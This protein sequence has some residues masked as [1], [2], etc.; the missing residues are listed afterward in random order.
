M[1]RVEQALLIS[2]GRVA[3]SG[4]TLHQLRQL[5]VRIA[6]DDFGAGYSSLSYVQNFAYDKLKIDRSFIKDV[7]TKKDA[8]KILWA[9]VA[10]VRCFGLR[11]T[12]EGIET[13]EQLDLV[14]SEGCDEIQGYFIG[15][16]KPA[17]DVERLYLSPSFAKHLSHL[18]RPALRRQSA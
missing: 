13:Q 6:L 11:T 12:V 1:I 16:P 18:P 4:A 5:G 10:L 9:V 7:A 8:A 15:Q 2:V 3:S 14:W 17:D